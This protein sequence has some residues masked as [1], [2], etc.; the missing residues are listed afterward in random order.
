MTTNDKTVGD[1]CESLLQDLHNAQN[2]WAASWN[3][4][5]YMSLPPAPAAQSQGDSNA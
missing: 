5:H 2:H 3:P 1:E 4:S